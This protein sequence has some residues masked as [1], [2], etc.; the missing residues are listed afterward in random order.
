MTYNMTFN[1][2]KILL[3]N[4][5]K[6][7]ASYGKKTSQITTSE[8]QSKCQFSHISH[9][10]HVKLQLPHN[11]KRQVIYICE[12]YLDILFYFCNG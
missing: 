7:A 8:F 5:L 9:S 10:T 12:D 2:N 6:I 11:L 3:L 4:S 1:K